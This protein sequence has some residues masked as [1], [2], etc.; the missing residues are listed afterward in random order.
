[1]QAGLPAPMTEI[2]RCSV[3]LSHAACRRLFF[4][5]TSRHRL[6]LALRLAFY[7]VSCTPLRVSQVALSAVWG[8]RHEELRQARAVEVSLG[9]AF[10]PSS[11]AKNRLGRHDISFNQQVTVKRRAIA[12]AG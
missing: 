3:L 12:C 7:G 10:S 9:N 8:E 2:D 4:L 6:F 11:P 1:M 5:S